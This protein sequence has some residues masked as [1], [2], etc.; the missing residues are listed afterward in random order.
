MK[1]MV[2]LGNMTFHHFE[3]EELALFKT[4]K[5]NKAL[6]HDLFTVI[7]TDNRDYAYKLGEDAE[8][9]IILPDFKGEMV[10]EH[11][12]DLDKFNGLTGVENDLKYPTLNV[13]FDADNIACMF[14]DEILKQ[15]PKIDSIKVNYPTGN[16]FIERDF[17]SFGWEISKVDGSKEVSV[18]AVADAQLFINIYNETLK[19]CLAE[20]TSIFEIDI[21]SVGQC[22]VC[23]DVLMPDDELYVDGNTGAHLC[24]THSTYDEANDI[25]VANDPD[26][27]EPNF[28]YQD[29]DEDNIKDMMKWVGNSE[30]WGLIDG[31]QGG[32]I[33]YINHQ[34]I[35]RI[36]GLLNTKN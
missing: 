8:S 11:K 25:Y 6:I 2:I 19:Y 12:W 10:F 33:G 36:A 27:E 26:A 1:Y 23:D 17:N 35:D 15:F 22:S 18:M 3:P 28:T 34:H 7:H 29:L 30:L 13:F 14:V 24:D 20:N 16:E 9:Y 31:E 4:D 32:I 21:E 5:E